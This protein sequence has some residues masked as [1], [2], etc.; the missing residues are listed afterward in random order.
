MNVRA[1][2]VILMI[3][4]LAG[5][6]RGPANDQPIEVGARAPNFTLVDLDGDRQSLTR[7]RGQPIVLSFWA[8][9][10]QPCHLE[11]PALKELDES[12]QIQ[13]LSIAIDDSGEEIVRPFVEERGI[14]YPVLIGNQDTMASYQGT[15][16]PYTFV[17]DADHVIRKIYRSPVSAQAILSDLLALSPGVGSIGSR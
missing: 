1:G 12:S 13:V 5:C 2:L 17:L 16:I 14:E 3:V 6:Q 15:T 9:W 8:T 4:G 10:C 11:I 7:Y